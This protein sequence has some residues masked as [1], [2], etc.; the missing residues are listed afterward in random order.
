MRMKLIF[1]SL[2]KLRYFKKWL[3]SILCIRYLFLKKQYEKKKKVKWWYFVNV[4]RSNPKTSCGSRVGLARIST[5]CKKLEKIENRN[6]LC[7]IT[8]ANG[9]HQCVRGLSDVRKL[10]LGWIFT[11]RGRLSSTT[12]IDGKRNRHLSRSRR[13]TNIRLRS[14]AIMILKGKTFHPRPICSDRVSFRTFRFATHVLVLRPAPG[15]RHPPVH[16]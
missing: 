9:W 5:E 14:C 2:I 10:N 13:K 1:F 8:T 6:G 7:P 11:T 15:R 3:I 16:S 4:G 12:V